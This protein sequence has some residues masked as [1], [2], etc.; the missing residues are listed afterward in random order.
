MKT[1]KD[2]FE[3]KT[4]EDLKDA[5]IMIPKEKKDQWAVSF[6]NLYSHNHKI[7]ASKESKL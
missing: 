6:W 5:F 4:L 1:K 2:Y 7:F 3:I